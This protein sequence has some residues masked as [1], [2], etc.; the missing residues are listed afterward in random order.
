MRGPI[1]YT[2]CL[3]VLSE[4]VVS[5]SFVWLPLTQCDVMLII[6]EPG[7]DAVENWFSRAV[8]LLE[9]V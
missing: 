7:F 9:A 8:G 1:P 3:K 2:Q 6:C 4:Y 5:N